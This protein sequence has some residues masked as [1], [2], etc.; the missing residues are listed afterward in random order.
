MVSVIESMRKDVECTFGILKG[1]WRILKSGV[2]LHGSET[3]DAIW[4]TCC[5]LHNMLLEEDGLDKPW[6]GQTVPTSEWEGN[7]GAFE[8]GDLPA[9]FLRLLRPAQARAYDTSSTGVPFAYGDDAEE[10]DVALIA[11]VDAETG[12]EVRV[13]RKLSMRYFRSKLVEHFDIKWRQ[14]KIVW[15]KS[16]GRALTCYVD[17]Y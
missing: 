8:D 1:R 13:V 6:D 5:A 4:M 3:V 15:P 9:P 11:D 7:L 17:R 16:R 12:E 2:R 14:G 10:E